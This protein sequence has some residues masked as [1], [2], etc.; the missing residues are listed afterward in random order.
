MQQEEEEDRGRQT[1]DACLDRPPALATARCQSV[2][3]W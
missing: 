1:V 3:R 2:L